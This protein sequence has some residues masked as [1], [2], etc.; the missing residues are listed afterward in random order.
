MGQGGKALQAVACNRKRW[1]RLADLPTEPSL[2][3]GRGAKTRRCK[4]GAAPGTYCHRFHPVRLLPFPEHSALS[5]RSGC[6]I[7]GAVQAR[8][9]KGKLGVRRRHGNARGGLAT[10]KRRE[11]AGSSVSKLAALSNRDLRFPAGIHEC[12]GP[13]I[14]GTRRS[15]LEAYVLGVCG[16]AN[17]LGIDLAWK[18]REALRGGRRYCS[19]GGILPCGWSRQPR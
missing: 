10:N 12:E 1:S 7:G 14:D 11:G 4:P 17:D 9:W 15:V 19:I 18:V 13:G 2:E 16:T 8:L 6:S 3:P 5:H